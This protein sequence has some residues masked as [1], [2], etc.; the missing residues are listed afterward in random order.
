MSDYCTYT[1]IKAAMPDAIAT[2]SSSYDTILGTLA[3]RASRMI[4]AVFGYEDNGFT[5]PT[6]ASDRYYNGNGRSWLPIDPCTTISAVAVKANETASD[7][8]SWTVTTDYL[9]AAGGVRDPDWNAGYYTL[10]LVTPG[11]AK[12]FTQGVKT[13]KVTMKYG[14]SATVPD[15]IK[16]AAIIQAVRWFKR[17]QSAFSDIAGQTPMGE[18]QYVNQLDPDIKEMLLHSPYRRGAL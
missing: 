8:T 6:A 15:I 12:T 2:T 13:V 10:L 4:D 16:Q 17:G 7:Y 9:A 18:L 14:R 5:A 3:T 11:V 1:E